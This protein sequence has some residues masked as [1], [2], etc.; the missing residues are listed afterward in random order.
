MRERSEE[1]IRRE[2]TR[3]ERRYVRARRVLEKKREG[4]GGG[5]QRHAYKLKSW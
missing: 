3:R 2:R 5:K 4:A 1:S